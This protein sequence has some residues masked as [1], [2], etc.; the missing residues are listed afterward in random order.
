MGL[1]RNR[2]NAGPFRRHDDGRRARRPTGLVP[3]E[4]PRVDAEPQRDAP[5]LEPIPGKEGGDGEGVVREGHGVGR[6]RG[7]RGPVGCGYRPGGR[8]RRMST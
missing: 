3:A 2:S 8:S 4:Q 6:G 7:P 5:R 1:T